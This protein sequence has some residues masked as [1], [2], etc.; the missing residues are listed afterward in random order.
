MPAELCEGAPAHTLVN[1]GFKWKPVK[2][3]DIGLNI[4]N[5]LNKKPYYDPN[6]WEGYNHSLN[7]FGRQFAISANYRFW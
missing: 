2:H 7:L 3:L 4:K 6:G 1:L 5:A